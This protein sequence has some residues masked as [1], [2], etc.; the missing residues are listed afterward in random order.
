[1][2]LFSKVYLGVDI[3]HSSVKVVGVRGGAHPAFVGCK[4][5]TMDPKFLQKEGFDNHDLIGQAL[6]EAM[7]TAA[8][9]P[10]KTVQ[11]HAVVS[12]PLLFRKVIELPVLSDSELPGVVRLAA[13]EFLPDG[14]EHFE[15]SYQSLGL[16]RP[17]KGNSETPSIPTQEV[18]MLALAKPIVEDYLEVFKAAKLKLGSIEPKPTALVRALKVAEKE[19]LI[20]LTD[21]GSEISTISV[22]SNGLVWAAS[23]INLGGNVIRDR[24]TH[25]VEE[26]RRE[27]G[28]KRLSEALAEE[29]D[30]IVKFYINRSGD[31]REIEQVYLTGGGSMIE[32]VHESF[33]KVSSHPVSIATPRIQLPDFCDRRFAGALG[34]ALYST[35]GTN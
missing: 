16:T 28:I 20:V 26:E 6:C 19:E 12:E 32:G 13:T 21:I 3:G 8:P 29:V 27:A 7:A 14:L 33:A 30:H 35:Y 2:G 24:Q 23:S 15:I 11:A 31:E 5:I 1:M 9:H 25:E 22:C 4:E 18:A 34:A 17:E 10:I